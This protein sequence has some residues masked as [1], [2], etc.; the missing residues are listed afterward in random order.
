MKNVKILKCM[1]VWLEFLK[2]KNINVFT[3]HPIHISGFGLEQYTILARDK[4]RT[5]AYTVLNISLYILYI[6]YTN[7]QLKVVT[8]DNTV[9]VQMK[10]CTGVQWRVLNVPGE[11]TWTVCPLGGGVRT[12]G[13]KSENFRRE[14]GGEDPR[15]QPP[16]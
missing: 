9:F 12:T 11:G 15:P 5:Q 8:E 2:Y 14:E 6:V 7:Y 10:N 13:L 3:S 1:H 16:S 4:H